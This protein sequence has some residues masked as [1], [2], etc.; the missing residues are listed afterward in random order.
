MA[1]KWI[2]EGE[3]PERRFVIEH[4]PPVGF[5]F[6]VFEGDRCTHDYLQDGIE[7]AMTQAEEDFCIPRAAWRPAPT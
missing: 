3:A 1:T 6:Y 2:A 7:D 5:Y 4:A